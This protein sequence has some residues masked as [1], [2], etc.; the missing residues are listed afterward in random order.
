[1]V[2]GG[3]TGA[4]WAAR[5]PR[6]VLPPS[7]PLFLAFAISPPARATDLPVFSAERG[8]YDAPV[9]VT[10]TPG[11]PTDTLYCST[12]HADPTALCVSP[13][14]ISATTTLRVRAVGAD[15]TA[16]ATT[17][18]Y[19]FPAD[20][21]A[22]PKMDANI[23][24]DPEYG[25]VLDESLRTLPSISLVVPVG[26]TETEQAASVEWIDPAGPSTEVNCGA[27]IIGGTSQVYEKTS[28][29]LHFRSSYG[30]S[31]WKWDVY[32]AYPVGVAPVQS[33][34][35]ITL[36]GGNHDSVFYLGT[37]GQYTRN[38]WMDETQLE[39]GQL[40]PHGRFVHLYINGSY[41]GQYH[42]RERFAAGFLSSYLGGSKDDYDAINGGSPYDGTVT[43][44]NQLV[45]DAATGDYAAVQTRLNVTD[46]LD[47]MVLQWY[48]ANA[49][50]WTPDHNWISGG[51]R[52]ANQGG[53]LFH[54][55]DA[56]ISLYYPP[57]TNILS[58][59]GPSFLMEFLLADADPAFLVALE[60]AI[61]RNLEAD[62]PLTAARAAARYSRI[63]GYAEPGIVPESARFGYGAWSLDADWIPERDWLLNDFFAARTDEL[64][65]EV[66]AAGWYPLDAPTLDTAAGIV[67]V[68][69]AVSVAAPTTDAADLW[70]TTDGSDPR[71]ADGTVVSTA[72]GPDRAQSVSLVHGATVKARV[73]D[74][75]TWGPL[76]QA[77]YD[78]DEAPPIVLNEWNAV[79]SDSTLKNGDA[80]LGTSAGNGG[81]WLELLVLEDHLDLRGWRLEMRDLRQIP[82]TLTFTDDSLLEDLRAG[83]ILTIAADLPED[84]SY[85]P[86]NG[87]WRFHL[88]A[89][90]DDAYVRPTGPSGTFEVTDKDWQLTIRDADGAIR[91]PVVGEGQHGFLG[92]G[93]DEVGALQDTPTGNFRTWTGAFHDADSSSYGAPNTWKGGAQDL[94]ALRGEDG[95]IT[96][97][98]DSGGPGDTAGPPSVPDSTPGCGCS[99]AS[100]PGTSVAAAVGLFGVL[101]LRRRPA[102][103]WT[104]PMVAVVLVACTAAA[105]PSQVDSASVTDPGPAA[106]FRDLDGD[107][108]GDPAAPRRCE[109]SAVA[110]GTDCDDTAPDVHPGAPETCDGR[111]E[112][113]NGLVDDDAVDGLPFYMDEDGDGYGTT[114][115][116]ACAITTGYALSG[117][118]CDDS[119]ANVH[120]GASEGCDGVDTN[121]DGVVSTILG[122][123]S[124]CPASTCAEALASGATAS[125]A[126]WLTLT[127]GVLAEVWCDQVTDGGGWTL[128]FLRNS[129]SV[130]SQA[131]F[132][133]GDVTV[134]AL[135]GAPEDASASSAAA[136]GW[137]DLNLY[138]YD[139][140]R[141]AAY[142]NGSQTYLSRDIART[143]LNTAFGED[144]YKLYGG[145]SGY[146]WCGG[147]HTYTDYGQGAVNNPDGA[148]SDCKGHGSLGSG[149]DFSESPVPN[150]GLTLC[151]AD[152]SYFLTASW[153]GDYAYYGAA[154][155]AQAIWV[156]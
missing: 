95:A 40:A 98:A 100:A 57:D 45:S 72:T 119:N 2:G 132:G 121:C 86:E 91:A 6:L 20:V 113:C 56:D 151:G 117:G 126:T 32:G 127:S 53:F 93:S 111:D 104:S 47:Y 51:P 134:D 90:A 24:T 39:Q 49:W 27:G 23:V 7:L 110:D 61:H 50:D 108:F 28:F 48:A 103:P 75:A 70:V 142:R 116:T 107:G 15:G 38:Y 138:T 77:E 4:R 26:M 65:A 31:R 135:A 78:M 139:T 106:C 156:R 5:Y 109:G 92:L 46:F 114:L 76:A 29:R 25:P 68:G 17:E 122:S 33:F 63:A 55:S 66:K 69:T 99:T 125:G 88:R 94:S 141:L 74:G 152:G 34:D 41:N 96:P 136:I 131:L 130:D 36:R 10:L 82:W 19:L 140:L 44:W 105:P 54:S 71:A 137:L 67:P 62:G 16:A 37:A 52:A 153:A 12:D 11:L 85:D 87:D 102:R 30:A 59:A 115:T 89:S 73:L 133:S 21:E 60:D 18:T 8:L 81:D 83:T 128:G 43:A 150:Q 1:M 144:G 79:A 64:L 14:T 9:S 155:G 143:E 3:L 154:G 22:Q 101:L 147:N 124:G 42:V 146:Y 112:D 13:M 129:A 145:E 120:P 80:E 148:P 123:A 84:P 58:N 118:D 149:W 97:L 35:T